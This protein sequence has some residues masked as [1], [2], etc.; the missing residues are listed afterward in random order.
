MGVEHETHQL[1]EEA[2]ALHF[3]DDAPPCQNTEKACLSIPGKQQPL[4]CLQIQDIITDERR[5]R[6]LSS[7]HGGIKSLRKALRAQT[8]TPKLHF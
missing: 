5:F 1:P 4:N 2:F 7:E 3:P 6:K 8:L